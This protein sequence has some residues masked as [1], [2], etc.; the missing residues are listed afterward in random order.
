MYSS[1]NFTVTKAPTLQ[2]MNAAVLVNVEGVANG[3]SIKLQ[4]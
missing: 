4:L 1:P 2:I 3:E